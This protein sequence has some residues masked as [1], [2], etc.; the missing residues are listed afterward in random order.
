MRARSLMLTLTIALAAAAVCPA[1]EAVFEAES[2]RVAA[3]GIPV[4]RTQ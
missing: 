1:G 2:A 3:T 4:E